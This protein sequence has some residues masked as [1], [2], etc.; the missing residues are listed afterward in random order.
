MLFSSS[1]SSCFNF[2]IATCFLVINTLWLQAQTTQ[3]PNVLTLNQFLDQHHIAPLPK[4]F[5]L[6]IESNS[7]GSTTVKSPE[8]KVIASDQFGFSV[9]YN[10]E[11]LRNYKQP[12]FYGSCIIEINPY[13][14]RAFPTPLVQVY[15]DVRNEHF[16]WERGAGLPTVRYRKNEFSPIGIANQRKSRLILNAEYSNVTRLFQ[17]V[18]YH[19][20][21]YRLEKQGKVGLAFENG[22][23]I[24]PA[25]Y[26]YI[27]YQL[28]F[29]EYRLFKNQESV[30]LVTSSGAKKLWGTYQSIDV[31]KTD[32]SIYVQNFVVKKDKKWGLLD[33][34]LRV[35]IPVEYD[36][37]CYDRRLIYDSP[38][39]FED[40]EQLLYRVYKAGNH[41]Y[42]N[43]NYELIIPPN[44]HEVTLLGQGLYLARDSTHTTLYT[45]KGKVIFSEPIEKM[46]AFPTL[47]NN[48]LQAFYL[49]KM[50][51]E[52]AQLQW[53]NQKG[54]WV[55]T[56]PYSD[57]KARNNGSLYSFYQYILVKKDSLWGAIDRHGEEWLAPVYDSLHYFN[58]GYYLGQQFILTFRNG[59]KGLI[60]L[61][62]DTV[63][64]PVYDNISMNYAQSMQLIE[65]VKDNQKGLVTVAGEVVVPTEFD[66]IDKKKYGRCI[67]VQKAD[68]FGAFSTE[69]TVLVPSQYH[70]W[71]PRYVRSLS[72]YQLE[73]FDDKTQQ[74]VTIVE[75]VENLN[76]INNTIIEKK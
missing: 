39:V 64:P 67:V 63:L 1:V 48:H 15:E 19:P 9:F 10:N 20:F 59:K 33:S 74:D 22:K 46:D 18:N 35:Q 34:A 71:Q 32:G 17:R 65:V 26:D 55:K 4:A 28:I 41:G 7:N 60:T 5:N 27:S 73:F 36:S 61:R 54:E 40:D 13:E 57:F 29:Q 21:V 14:Y 25:E 53:F 58:P 72:T 47:K 12:N 44:Y 3:A 2:Y 69:G 43:G 70:F 8:G 51:G 75:C 56:L 62:G 50:K 30:G 16:K 45:I 24:L 23:L 66:F 31:L 11:H 37:I 76:R 42:F 49:F 38:E 68:L 6:I 52:T